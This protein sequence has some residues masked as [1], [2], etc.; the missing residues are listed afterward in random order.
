MI[1]VAIA[2]AGAV[3][4][5]WARDDVLDT[6]GFVA[7]TAPVVE[8]GDVHD[9]VGAIAG[10]QRAAVLVATPEVQAAWRAA[11]ATAHAQARALI[12]GRGDRVVLDLEP[13]VGAIAAR[14]GAVADRSETRVVVLDAKVTDGARDVATWAQ[15]L[16]VLLPAIVGGG[17]VALLLLPGRLRA[18]TALFAATALLFAAASLAAGDAEDGLA[19]R[20][21]AG[22]RGVIE[23]AYAETLLEPLQTDLRRGLWLCVAAACATGAGALLSNRR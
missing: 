9:A 19:E 20:A 5:L 10:D 21:P 13:V 3:I 17:V 2:L 12:R 16:A 15:R 23:R 1:V 22:A 4:A 18:F 7:A 6:G 8:R 11:N 14:L